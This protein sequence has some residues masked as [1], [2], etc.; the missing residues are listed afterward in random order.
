MVAF[1]IGYETPSLKRQEHDLVKVLR[2]HSLQM[3]GLTSSRLARQSSCSGG[4]AFSEIYCKQ[5]NTGI[6]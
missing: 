2:G 3:S 6:S 4:R 5:L 1:V